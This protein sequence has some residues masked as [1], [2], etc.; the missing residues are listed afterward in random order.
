VAASRQWDEFQTTQ[1][2][3]RTLDVLKQIVNAAQ[4]YGPHLVWAS[5]R[6]KRDQEGFW[7]EMEEN[8]A[9]LLSLEIE[10]GQLRRAKRSD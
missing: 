9:R 8:D 1:L 5:K 2:T 4:E 3:L 7:R 10:L 6:S